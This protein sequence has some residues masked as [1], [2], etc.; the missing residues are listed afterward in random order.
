MTLTE[1]RYLVNLDR[2]RHFGRAAERS[3]VSQPTL[4]V[5][6]KKLEDTLGV[7][8]F[9]R[10]RGEARPTPIG[11]RIIAQAKRVLAEARLIEDLARA[12]RD[13]LAGP[14]RFGAIYTVGPY[15]LPNLVPLL[16]ERVPQMPLVIEENFTARLLEQLRDNELDVICVALPVDLNGLSAWPVYDEDFMVL[17]PPEH[18][19]AK[20]KAIAARELA[21]EPL[22]LLGPGHCFREQVIEACPKCIDPDR[23]GPQPQT[24][25]SL[26]TIRH[27]VVGGLG[28]TVLPQSSVD[29]RLEERARLLAKPF[30]PPGPHRSIALVWRKTYPR[31][32]AITQLRDAILACGMKG[33]RYRPDEAM[34]A[35]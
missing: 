15:L 2:E 35:E 1:L 12:G 26:E 9:E 32:A 16:R 11:E 31:R 18:H 8:L 28:I 33:V 29:N 25:S 7:I 3:F 5:A 10:N 17:M 6:L 24:G 22:L 23:D 20:E 4:S 34:P 21:G 19:W 14:L 13:E 27:M 30:V